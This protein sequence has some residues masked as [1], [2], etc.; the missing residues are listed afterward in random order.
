MHPTEK[1]RAAP[2]GAAWAAALLLPVLA[3]CGGPAP[4]TFQGEWAGT[5]QTE[6]GRCPTDRPSRLL[7]DGKDISF[8]PGGGVLVLQGIRAPESKS[9]H[10]QLALTDADHKPLPMVFD[11][12]MAVDGTSIDGTYGTPACRASITLRRPEHHAFD[13]VLGK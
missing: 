1:S 5:L 11:G 8:V 10:A 6:K 7:V 9:L 12:T 3:A 4:G 13:R 2:I